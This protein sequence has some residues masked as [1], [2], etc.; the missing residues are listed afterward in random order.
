MENRT[1]SINSLI[2]KITKKDTLFNGA[3]CIDPYQNC[4][5]GCRY[6]DSS[7]E[8]TVYVKINACEVLENEIKNLE[9]DVIIIGSVHDPYQ[10]S[11]NKYKITRNLLITIKKNDFP[12]HILTKSPLVLRD[13]NL[14]KKMDCK[15]TTSIIS[16]D[17]NNNQIF[18]K[19]VPS[20][21]ERLKTVETLVKHG[22][23]AGVALIPLLPFLVESELEKII[24]KV[25][26]SNSEYFIYKNLELKGDQKKV[27][28]DIISDN[29]PHL[30]SKFDEL[31]KNKINP[32]DNYFATMNKKVHKLCRQYNIPEK[33]EF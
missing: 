19:N 24:K 25:S 10:N 29:Y 8:K 17:K 20:P 7:F 21:L 5:F 15:V 6:C 3:Y 32:E 16:L 31:Y 2:K 18:E 14:L 23:G 27:F 11:E 22:V 33:I 13:I 4:E 26:L 28:M 1:I 9:K 30:F 12:C